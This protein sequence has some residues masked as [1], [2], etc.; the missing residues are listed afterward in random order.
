MIIVRSFLLLLLLP[1]ISAC[2][3]PD[4]RDLHAYIAEVKAAR[5]GRI[6]PLPEFKAYETYNYSA[7]QLRSPFAP[8]VEVVAPPP[9]SDGVVQSLQPDLNRNRESL[10]AYP[11]DTL[12]YVGSFARDNNHWAII[13]SPDMLVHRVEVG[14]YL[15]SNYGKIVQINETTIQLREIIR[16][17]QGR[18]IERDA[19]LTLTE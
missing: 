8:I 7:G 6:A 9:A 4:N 18:W 13:T 17:G 12:R 15:G 2:N 10:E 16:D 14:N 1:L 5:P 11:L 19:A 3:Q